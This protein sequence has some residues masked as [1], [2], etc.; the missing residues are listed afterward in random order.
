[1]EYWEHPSYG[2]ENTSHKVI[3]VTLKTPMTAAQLDALDAASPQ[4]D[5]HFNDLDYADGDRVGDKSF[6][7]DWEKTDTV[8]RGLIGFSISR[9]EIRVWASEAI[10]PAYILEAT[11][12]VLSETA[13]TQTIDTQIAK[14]ATSGLAVGTMGSTLEE[15]AGSLRL[16]VR[17]KKSVPGR[18]GL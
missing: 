10:T 8:P 1:M 12:F 14:V 13:K 2:N 3:T 4:L 11:K 6:S 16:A 7:H 18:R 5:M 17:T 15:V 9:D